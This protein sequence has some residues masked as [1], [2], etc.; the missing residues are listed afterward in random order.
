MRWLTAGESHGPALVATLDGVPS[1]VR[2]TTETVRDALARRRLGYGRGARQSFERDEVR[3]LGGVRHGATTGAPIAV[4]IANA[5]WPKWE[6]VMSADPVPPEALLVD[7]GT[8][9]EREVARN[10]A[11]TRPRPGHADL[12]G[13]L[14]YDLA[15]ARPVLERASARETAARVALGALAEAYLEQ[16][17]GIRLVSH[18]V[19]VGAERASGGHAPRPEDAA[20]L[21]ASP[22]RT[23]DPRAER[24]FVEAIDAARRAGDTIG[25]IAEVIAWGVPVGLGTHV[26]ADRRL[27]ARLAGAL[28]SIQSVK[29]VE[30]GDGFA[31]AALPGSRAHDEIVRGPD[32]RLTRTSNHAGGIEGG[33]SDGEPI[34]VRAAFKP[35]STVPRALRTVDLA[36]GGDTTALHQRSDTCQ[37]VP[38][39]VIAQAEAA[40]V[41]ADALG[42]HAGGNSVAEARR[43]LSAYLDR[44][45]ERA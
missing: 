32:G 41:L 10:R 13:M 22:V 11:L 31:Q 6:V 29:G 17:A 27:D 39:A 43:N 18:V 9:D 2:I 7:A 12:A 25:G 28:M 26:Q 16:V 20:A 33:T 34:V 23:L 15:E 30:V 44:V 1:G 19:S 42:D 21:D 24:R 14:S 37:V 3:L 45:R 4:E 35:I 5:E 36:T 38:G 8:G 40:L